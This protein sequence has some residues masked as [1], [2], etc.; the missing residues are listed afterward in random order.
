L[1]AAV[2]GIVALRAPSKV[3]AVPQ[4]HGLQRV[5][6]ANHNTTYCSLDQVLAIAQLFRQSS[7]PNMVSP[8][9]RLTT[10]PGFTLFAT[11]SNVTTSN[12]LRCTPA[13]WQ[14]SSDTPHHL[15]ARIL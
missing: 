11:M 4:C 5:A 15:A 12:W 2:H 8:S 14:L 1:Q 10:A 7:C 13:S 9:V 6:S 3:D